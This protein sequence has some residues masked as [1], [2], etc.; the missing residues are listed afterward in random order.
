MEKLNDVLW[1]SNEDDD[2][3]ELQ[4]KEMS[5]AC[6]LYEG[7]ISPTLYIIKCVHTL[8]SGICY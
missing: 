6:E 3:V 2:I 8:K 4:G 7:C 1:S 5:I